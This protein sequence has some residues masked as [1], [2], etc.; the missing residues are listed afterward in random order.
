[1]MD[2]KQAKFKK[3]PTQLNMSSANMK[4]VRDF[5][6]PSKS[7]QALNNSIV[8]P[9]IDEEAPFLTLNDLLADLNLGDKETKDQPKLKQTQLEVVKTD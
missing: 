8:G 9:K 1:M 5:F 4:P 3:K 7:R 6:K 2:A